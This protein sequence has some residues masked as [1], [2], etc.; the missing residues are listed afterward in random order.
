MATKRQKIR[1]AIAAESKLKTVKPKRKRKPMSEEQRAAAAERLAKAREKRMAEQGPPKNVHPDV[2][3]KPDEDTLS[4]KNVRSWIK[5]Q[6]GLLQAARQ[7]ERAGLK[8]ALAKRVSIEGYIRNLNNYIAS[9]TYCDMFYGEYGNQ[10]MRTVCVVPAYDKDGNIK[11]N[12]GT[13]YQDINAVYLGPGRI[14]R[15]GEEI[16]VDYV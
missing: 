7:E 12:A 15:D 13:W 14:E 6:Q 16:E 1:E 10:K 9:G 5:T 3:A 11:R 8:G 4:L 2:L